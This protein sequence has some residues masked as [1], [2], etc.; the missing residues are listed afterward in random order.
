MIKLNSKTMS[1]ANVTLLDVKA[2]INKHK[3]NPDVMKIFDV[4][5]TLFCYDGVLFKMNPYYKEPSQLALHSLWA[6]TVPILLT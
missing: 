4:F 6:F 2:K 1:G 5:S 3:Q